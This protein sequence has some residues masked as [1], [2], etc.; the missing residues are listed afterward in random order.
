MSRHE[1]NKEAVMKLVQRRVIEEDKVIGL[2]F[3]ITMSNINLSKVRP[4]VRL[5]T[6]ATS[7]YPRRQ[8]IL[9]IIN[10]SKS[11]IAKSNEFKSDKS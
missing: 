7:P 3:T 1:T 5:I 2:D 4:V 6:L 8:L 11:F 9:F 10:S